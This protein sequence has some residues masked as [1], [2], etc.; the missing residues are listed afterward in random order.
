MSQR[1][2]DPKT[3]R[4]RQV[5]KQLREQRRVSTYAAAKLC[6]KSATLISHLENGW[7]P[8]R[9]HHLDWL[10]PMYG[11]TRRQYDLMLK[12]DEARPEALRGVL[13]Q[14]VME[15]PAGALSMVLDLLTCVNRGFSEEVPS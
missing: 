6:G 15:L 9:D 1:I 14:R 3:I 7:V 13:Q 4:A 11:A 2:E 5:L 12:S 8:L 10:L